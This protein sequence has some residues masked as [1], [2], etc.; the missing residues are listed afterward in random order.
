MWLIPAFTDMHVHV[1]GALIPELP[2]GPEEILSPYLANGIVQLVD[3]ASSESTN[4]L[5]DEIAAGGLRAPRL[6]TARMVD[7][8]PPI[9]GAEIATVARTPDE[10]RQAVLDIVAAG[11]DFI[12]VYSRLDVEP[13]RALLDAAAEQEI[14]VIGHIPARGSADVTDVLLPGLAMVAHAEEF[15]FASPDKSDAAIAEYVGLARE[16]GL[17]AYVNPLSRRADTCPDA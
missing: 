5:R 15:A 1:I 4:A 10:A 7:G 17:C 13:F 11:Y 14:R 12:K 8:D 6:A 2:F 16:I 3:L 9:W